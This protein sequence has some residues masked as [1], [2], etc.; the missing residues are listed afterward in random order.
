MGCMNIDTLIAAAFVVGILYVLGGAVPGL[1]ARVL[2]AL[3]LVLVLPGA[4]ELSHRV[5]AAA[6]PGGKGLGLTMDGVF[7][8]AAVLGAAGFFAYKIVAGWFIINMTVGLRLQRVPVAVPGADGQDLSPVTDHLAIVV[9]LEKGTTDSVHLRDI[10]VRV[11]DLVD[12]VA[13]APRLVP[14]TGFTRL[15]ENMCAGTALW[16]EV[17]PARP[18]SF[19]NP[20]RTIAI[21]PGEKTE[22]ACCTPVGHASAVLVEAVVLG[23][24]PLSVFWNGFFSQ[25]RVSAVSLPPENKT[26]DG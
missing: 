21:S 14:L 3:L 9:T 16:E 5:Q 13:R 19:L 15:R 25:W 11:S 24:R 22:F 23:E 6:A 12:G 7:K 4:L 17:P 1:R 20:Q 18:W 8:G 26:K 10:Q 2:V